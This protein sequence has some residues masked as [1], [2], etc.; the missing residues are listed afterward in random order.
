[1][2]VNALISVDQKSRRLRMERASKD[3]IPADSTE[4]CEGESEVMI[5]VP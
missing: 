1:M 3:D 4:I 2:R 5:L